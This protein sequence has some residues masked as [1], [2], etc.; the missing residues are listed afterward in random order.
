VMTIT[1]IQGAAA[2]RE[3]MRSRPSS[4]PRRR[5]TKARSKDCREFSASASAHIAHAGDE[6]AVRLQGQRQDPPDIDLVIDDEDVER[7][8]LNWRTWRSPPGTIVPGG[9]RCQC[10]LESADGLG[11]A[12]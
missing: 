5:S 12:R 11:L 8:G 4:T 1:L 6:V 10:G 7:H 3:G 9:K 2:R